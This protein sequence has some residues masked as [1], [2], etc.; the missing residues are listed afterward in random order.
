MTSHNISSTQETDLL[1]AH[2]GGWCGD[3]SQLSKVY[4]SLP[5]F[6]WIITIWLIY[7]SGLELWYRAS[8]SIILPWKSGS[9]NFIFQALRT[10]DPLVGRDPEG[11]SMAD[12]STFLV[13]IAYSADT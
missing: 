4:I 1:V 3:N 7:D 11:K 10:N 9:Q 5:V 13:V 12:G 8:G 6:Y 2:T